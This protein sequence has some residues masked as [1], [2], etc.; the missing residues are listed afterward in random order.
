MSDFA[1]H[2]QHSAGAREQLA[3]AFV[4][5][6]RDELD[7]IRATTAELEAFDIS[8]WHRVQTAAHNIGARAQAVGLAVLTSCARELEQFSGAMLSGDARDRSY[9]MQRAM[10]ALEALDLE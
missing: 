7:R 4:R 8:A 9:T 3:R 5:E 2:E 6:V 1:S 10:V